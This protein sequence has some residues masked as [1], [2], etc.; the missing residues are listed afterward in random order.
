MLDGIE[1]IVHLASLTHIE[2]QR[3]KKA[4]NIWKIN[5]AG[6]TRLAEEAV[7][8]GITRFIFIST[9]K[10]L[11]ERTGRYS[12]GNPQY[13][14]ECNSPS[15]SIPYAMSKFET[16][17]V[18]KEVCQGFPMEY[19]IFRPPLLYGPGV[20]ANFLHLLD[21]I[22]REIPLP[23]AYVENMRSLL[24]VDNLCHAIVM[25]L[26]HKSAAN[27]IYLIKDIDISLLDL[28]KATSR[29]FGKKAMLFPFPLSLLRLAG[30]CTGKSDIIYRLTDSILV[31][32][33]K[34]RSELRWSPPVSFEEGLGKTVEWYRKAVTGE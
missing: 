7:L 27:Q 12:D 6:T 16:E 23:L 18:I 29:M 8:R 34:L 10:V 1:M 17:E 21:M 32:D 4:G 22:Y 14:T 13:F 31:D 2:Q 33:G 26:R 30:K 25:S 28:V 19:T 9:V 3:W 15:P 5:V 24:F 11:G 20:K